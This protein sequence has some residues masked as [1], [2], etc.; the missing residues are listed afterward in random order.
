MPDPRGYLAAEPELEDGAGWTNGEPKM[1]NLGKPPAK[2][3]QGSRKCRGRCDPVD[4]V[5]ARQS[6]AVRTWS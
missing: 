4:A 1:K 6:C 5:D 2:S 3:S